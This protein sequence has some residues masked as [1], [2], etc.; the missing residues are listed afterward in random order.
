MSRMPIIPTPSHS[1][2]RT[3]QGWGGTSR[4]AGEAHPGKQ[5]RHIPGSG[6]GCTRRGGAGGCPRGSPRLRAVPG[7]AGARGPGQPHRRR[8]LAP[9]PPP[10]RSVLERLSAARREPPPAPVRSRSS[11]RADRERAAAPPPAPGK[12]PL[13]P[14]P[15]K[16]RR[17][18]FPDSPS[19][20]RAPVREGRATAGAP[21]RSAAASRSRRGQ[22]G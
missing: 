8:R 22:A 10:Q 13:L 7:G 1:Q 6:A 14:P 21:P 5:G 4:E 16:S 17:C 15:G 19:R 20:R 2:R 18:L 9:P 3:Q 11:L 12:L